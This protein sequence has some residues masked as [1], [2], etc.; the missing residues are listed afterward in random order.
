MSG[1]CQPDNDN[2]QQST[3][4]IEENITATTVDSIS[5]HTVIMAVT[6]E[7][8]T[9]EVS[10]FAVGGTL[11]YTAIGVSGVI[12]FSFTIII[13][14]ILIGFSVRRKRKSKTFITDTTLDPHNGIQIQGTGY[15]A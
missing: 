12:I 13:A 2:T 4:P 1:T 5:A 3:D 6:V 8:T 9:N 7:S 15:A 10:I 14:C 11:F